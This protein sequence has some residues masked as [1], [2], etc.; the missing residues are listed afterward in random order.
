MA[1]ISRTPLYLITILLFPVISWGWGGRGHAHICEAASYLVENAELKQFLQSRA[2]IM[3]HL[4]NIPDTYWKSLSGEAR[5]LGDPTHYI[6]PEVIGVTFEKIPLDSFKTLEKKYL[7]KP[8]QF[9]KDHPPILSLAGEFG[10]LFWRVEQLFNLGSSHFKQASQ[11]T[12]PSNKSEEQNTQLP[13]NKEVYEGLVVLG[14]M[15]HFIGD[16]VQ[17]YHLTADYDG[18]QTGHGGIHAF[19]EEEAVN[20]LPGDWT[21]QV[22]AQA[23]L[24]KKEWLKQPNSP[25]KEKSTLAKVKAV[26]LLSYQELEVITQID[27][28]TQASTE[29]DHKGLLIKKPAVRS[30]VTQALP[31]WTPYLKNQMAR[32]AL[33]LAHLWDQAYLQKNKK[34]WP[35]A[36]YKSYQHPFT[37]PFIKPDYHQ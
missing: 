17:P 9:K 5:S 29:Q 20:H 3:A 34:S 24:L 35:L 11:H 25:L 26:T 19:Y 37:V 21:Q 27:P 8:N 6:D 18:Y 23:E 36:K 1:F 28:V 10:S 22:L 12:P 13:F 14:V 33:L 7:K 2:Y 31:Q 15:G 16:G 4:C 30:A 32:G